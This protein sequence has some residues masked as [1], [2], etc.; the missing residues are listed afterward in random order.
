MSDEPSAD[1]ADENA[2][3]RPDCPECGR[4]IATVMVIGPTDGLVAPCGCRTPP[5]AL[6]DPR[7]E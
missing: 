5:A 1:D 2:P 4:T 3:A 6:E 7:L